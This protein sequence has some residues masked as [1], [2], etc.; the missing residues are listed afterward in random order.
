MA[1]PE[2]LLAKYQQDFAAYDSFL[3][4]DSQAPPLTQQQPQQR[5]PRSSK[6]QQR[7]QQHVDPDAT[8]LE[9]QGSELEEERDDATGRPAQGDLNNASHS[10]TSTSPAARPPAPRV[11]SAT[12]A[13]AVARAIAA[14]GGL[15][16]PSY[17]T[18]GRASHLPRSIHNAN[19]PTA[20]TRTSRRRTPADQLDEVDH[21]IEERLQSAGRYR[22]TS[23]PDAMYIKSQAWAQRRRQ[24]NEALRHEQADSE[25]RACTFQPQL[26][27]AAVTET[28]SCHFPPVEDE[29]PY[30]A[31]GVSVTEDP[32]VAQHLARLEAARRRRQEAQAR[33]DGSDHHAKWTGRP[34]VPRAPAL[35][36]RVAEPIPSLRKPCAPVPGEVE[37]WLA[38]AHHST[39]AGGVGAGVAAGAAGKSSSRPRVVFGTV[40]SAEKAQASPS[41]AQQKKARGPRAVNAGAATSSSANGATGRRRQHEVGVPQSDGQPPLIRAPSPHQQ[42][43]LN[44]VD[45]DTDVD[46]TSAQAMTVKE[47]E[48]GGDAPESQDLVRRLSTQLAHKDAVIQEQMSDL[49]RLHRELEAVKETLQQIASMGTVR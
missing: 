20:P 47:K 3:Q 48:E 29:G 15:E 44:T 25:M 4:R 2:A 26:G 32:G 43:A 10:G 35:G 36:G 41:A 37:P 22:T 13:A 17:D 7:Q 6:L 5:T 42:L 38:G 18:S 49:E 46:L 14:H 11:T 1:D 31:A 28:D 33:L 30:A 45:Y 21:L 16:G 24:I 8:I 40:M 23:S 9:M 27:P 39:H 12:S 34:T 19:S